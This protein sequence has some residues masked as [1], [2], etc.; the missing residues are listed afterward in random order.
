MGTLFRSEEMTLCQLYLQNEAA[1]ACISELGELG[2]AQFKD[3]SCYCQLQNYHN[4]SQ[5]H[6]C[7]NFKGPVCVWG[8]GRV[9]YWVGERACVRGSVCVC[10]NRI[11][12][13]LGP[14]FN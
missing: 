3:V 2:I 7:N 8:R 5:F 6:E 11:A 4:M 13:D 12:P 9:C 1:Y 10:P 14:A